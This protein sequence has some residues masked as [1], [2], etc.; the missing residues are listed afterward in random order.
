MTDTTES[1]GSA[2][3][4]FE[5]AAD[6]AAS[7][8]F[9]TTHWTAVVA[10]AETQSPEGIRALSELCS[11]YWC[12]LYAFARRQGLNQDEAADLTQGF[13]EQVIEKRLFKDAD[14]QRGR[15]R[16][17]LLGAFQHFLSNAR[18][19]AKALKRG[20]GFKFC[21]LDL[22]DAE[23]N[24]LH[25]PAHQLTPEKQFERDWAATFVNHVLD[26]L[27]AE[28]AGAAAERF[29]LMSPHLLDPETAGSYAQLAQSLGMTEGAVKTAM[30]R[31]RRRY[32]DLFRREVAVLVASEAEVE[33]EIRHMASI[34]A[35]T[36]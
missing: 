19:D 36:S 32:A 29:A 17:F 25:D 5:P 15:L 4:H 33:D 11:T 1:T 28:H 34:L 20:G 21:S 8:A 30:H 26:L 22:A 23:G 18:R 24:L 7:P 14:R 35:A 31:L 12:P 13:F 16:A 2:S 10:A 9:A 27:R 3:A 6:V